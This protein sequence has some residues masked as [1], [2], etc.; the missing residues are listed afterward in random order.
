MVKRL[1]RY[2]L[3]LLTHTI[4]LP[5]LLGFLCITE[6]HSHSPRKMKQPSWTLL[7][8][9]WLRQSPTFMHSTR[10]S[11]FTCNKSRKHT[12]CIKKLS[13]RNILACLHPPQ[14]QWS[15]V[16]ARCLAVTL[17]PHQP[18]GQMVSSRCLPQHYS[19]CSASGSVLIPGQS[20]CAVPPLLCIHCPSLSAC[21]PPSMHSS[22]LW[23]ALSPH[24][25]VTLRCSESVT[26]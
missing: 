11:L 23:C 22:I 18:L 2:D 4:F 25:F 24:V 12:T 16:I 26:A 7:P 3:P 20:N 9:V 14:L 1:A 10:P 5:H 19:C 21:I 17:R 8:I 6:S 15:A 13:F